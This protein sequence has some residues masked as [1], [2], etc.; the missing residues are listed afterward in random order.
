MLCRSQD[1][2]LNDIYDPLFKD[3]Q[4]DSSKLSQ[5]IKGGGKGVG[6]VGTQQVCQYNI[7]ILCKYNI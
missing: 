2:F 6:G 5:S 1:D 3:T 4:M 7:Y